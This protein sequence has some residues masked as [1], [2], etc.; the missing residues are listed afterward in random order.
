MQAL[1]PLVSSSVNADGSV[2]VT[3]RP[4]Q[5]LPSYT[6]PAN[7]YHSEVRYSLFLYY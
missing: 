3:F 2:T 6:L 7:Q 5:V 4:E 1:P